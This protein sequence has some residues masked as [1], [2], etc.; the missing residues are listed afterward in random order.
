MDGGF[1]R[2]AL[3]DDPRFEA[4]AR[5][6]AGLD[7]QTL[8]DLR[9][10]VREHQDGVFV[11]WPEMPVP[12]QRLLAVADALT[13][14]ALAFEA[15]VA[16]AFLAPSGWRIARARHALLALFCATT[17]ALAPVAGF[18]WL[19]L[20]M[21]IACCEPQRERMRIAYLV[22]FGVVLF[23]TRWPWLDWLVRTFA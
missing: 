21:G 3:V 14:S 9:A 12:P 10:L 16:V 20:S 2:V 7:A 23:A 17:Y 4:F 15:A 18:G 8:D 11:P 22:A 1:F 19:L 6:A 13:A 5:L